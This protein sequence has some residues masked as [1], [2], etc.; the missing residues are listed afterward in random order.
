MFCLWN[1]NCNRIS[2]NK[3]TCKI[4]FHL[5]TYITLKDKAL[6]WEQEIYN[7]FVYNK[8]LDYFHTFQADVSHI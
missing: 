1:S 4:H 6:L 3:F 2:Q 7:N 8:T 5:L